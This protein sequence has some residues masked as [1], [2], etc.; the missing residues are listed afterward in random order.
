MY[1]N[2]YEKREGGWEGYI[3]REIVTRIER[4][5][6]NEKDRKREREWEG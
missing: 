4:E 2:R 1:Y 3:K 5:R 6:E